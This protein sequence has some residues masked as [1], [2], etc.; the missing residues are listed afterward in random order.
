MCTGRNKNTTLA[1]T[2]VMEINQKQ[3]DRETLGE[4]IYYLWA[5]RLGQ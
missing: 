5:G 1:R 4:G 3:F 2:Y